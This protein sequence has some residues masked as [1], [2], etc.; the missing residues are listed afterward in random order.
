M[1]ITGIRTRGRQ[2]AGACF[3][4]CS[5]RLELRVFPAG[6]GPSAARRRLPDGL[7]GNLVHGKLTQER[8][9]TPY[10]WVHPDDDR[11][12]STKFLSNIQG[13]LPSIKN[14]DDP[15]SVDFESIAF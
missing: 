5:A 9:I 13:T 8:E 1:I 4:P 11:Q 7:S 2:R 12:V 10:V 6:V 14:Q 15:Q 3:R